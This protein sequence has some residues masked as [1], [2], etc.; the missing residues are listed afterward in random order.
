M[1]L[2]GKRG[3][4]APTAGEIGHMVV[5][6]DGARCGCGRR[7]CMEAYAGRE[8]MEAHARRLV[9]KGQ[10]TALFEIMEER[11]RDRPLERGLVTGARPRRPDGHDLIDEAVDALGGGV[12]SAVNLLDPEAVVIGGGLGIRLGEP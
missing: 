4:A 3:R 10:Q 7:G 6:V 11:G 12:A 8:S 5:R 2:D 9:G 1:I